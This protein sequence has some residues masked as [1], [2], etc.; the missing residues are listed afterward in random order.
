MTGLLCMESFLLISCG[1][2]GGTDCDGVS[3]EDMVSLLHE[4]SI[5]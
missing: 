3:A 5:E 1:E 2:G 4:V